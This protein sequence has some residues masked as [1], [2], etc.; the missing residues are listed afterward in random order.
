[1]HLAMAQ[2]ESYFIVCCATYESQILHN[3]QPR[4]KYLE[5]ILR[6]VNLQLQRQRCRRRLERFLHQ[7]KLIFIL[8]T[9]H[10]IT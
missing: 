9:L 10:T 6:L 1:M 4:S 8:K 5:P 3:F 2:L 7:Q